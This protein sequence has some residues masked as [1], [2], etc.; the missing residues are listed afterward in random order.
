[1]ALEKLIIEPFEDPG[2]STSAGAAFTVMVNPDEYSR[3]YGIKYANQQGSGSSAA[4]MKFARSEPEGITLSFF[5]DGTGALASDTATDVETAITSFEKVAY[6]YNGDIHSPN[7]LKISWGILI[8]KGRL[9]SYS[10]SY[11]LFKPDGTPLRAKVKA[12]FKEAIDASTIAKKEGDNSPD[13]THVRTVV[14]G[15]T[16]P[17]LCQ[18]IYKDPSMYLQVAKHN[19]LINLRRLTPGTELYFPPVAK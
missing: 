1:M 12:T 18:K 10:V 11:T 16:L 7:Y 19:N 4:P 9:Q 15:D 13:L 3:S 5:L 8:F 6:E 17:M 14:A 2:C